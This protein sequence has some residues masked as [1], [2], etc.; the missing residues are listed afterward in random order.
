M[1]ASDWYDLPLDGEDF[2]AG[3][4][5]IVLALFFI[6]L[7]AIV[8]FVMFRGSDETVG[9]RYLFS[10]AISGILL[11]FNY[12]VWPGLV[13]LTKSEITT[14]SMRPWVQ[15]YLDWAWFAMCYH[16]TVI[17]WS[18]FIAITYP[19]YFRQQTQLY[20]YSVCACCYAAALVQ[21]L[22]T[23]FQSWYVTFYYE[24]SA[25]GMLAENFEKY[26]NDGLSM[27]FFI[28]HLIMMSLPFV[29]YTLAIIF[30]IKHKRSVNASH[31][32]RRQ[33]TNTSTSTHHS[34]QHFIEMRLIAPCVFNTVL[35][36][37]G[38][39]LITLGTG[40]GKWATWSVMVL[41]CANPAV[42]PILLLVFSSAIRERTFDLLRNAL[43]I[44]ER[45]YSTIN[46]R[47]TSSKTNCTALSNVKL[48]DASRSATSSQTF[49]TLEARGIVTENSYLM[50]QTTDV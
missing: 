46:H 44:K 8:A 10:A 23:H 17:A 22:S 25:Y 31:L 7:Y 5:L 3:L 11:L 45:P 18:R 32:L 49:L 2:F 34:K 26:L 39:I 9:F 28:Y 30:L 38:Q 48:S 43:V 35:F 41:F 36:I 20:S 40:E 21:V 50:H 37:F 42:N 27:F 13:I 33:A 47:H 24:P 14:K 29:F 1:N 16:Y 19:S 12:G 4:S 15:M 6:F